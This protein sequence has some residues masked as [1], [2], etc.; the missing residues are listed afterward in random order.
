MTV[1]IGL[2][3]FD[4]CLRGGLHAPDLIKAA[5]RGRALPAVGTAEVV[6]VQENRETRV[7][8]MTGMSARDNRREH[9]EC[10]EPIVDALTEA[11]QDMVRGA[12]LYS[13]C[14]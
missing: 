11:D 10:S 14:V 5:S 2:Q 9:V 6:S 3:P 1:V 8:V 12:L 7:N 4:Y 13:R